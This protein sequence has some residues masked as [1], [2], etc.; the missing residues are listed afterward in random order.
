MSSQSHKDM[1]L[2]CKIYI[3][4]SCGCFMYNIK[5]GLAM[6]LGS[7]GGKKRQS[8]DKM[9]L[10]DNKYCI[11]NVGRFEYKRSDRHG[12]HS[13]IVVQ[14]LWTLLSLDYCCSKWDN[15]VTCG[16]SFLADQSI[17]VSVSVCISYFLYIWIMLD[18]GQKTDWLSL[19]CQVMAFSRR[20]CV[21]VETTPPFPILN[22]PT[23]SPPFLTII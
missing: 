8:K 6:S 23:P 20:V 11:V 19:K 12:L 10:A 2:C 16:V 22:L 14:F 18:L 5:S 1:T 21:P 17:Y 15:R 7:L 4:S 13:S 9:I 3:Q